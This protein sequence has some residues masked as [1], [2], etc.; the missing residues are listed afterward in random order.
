MKRGIGIKD[1]GIA[2]LLEA[3]QEPEVAKVT[4]AKGKYVFPGTI[5]IRARPDDPGCE[6]R[7]NYGHGTATTTMGGYTTIADM[8]P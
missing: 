2:A 6:W 7:R 5:S 8:P 4:D 1:D 3:E